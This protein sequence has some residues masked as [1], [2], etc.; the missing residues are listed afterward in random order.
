VRC[1]TAV[2]GLGSGRRVAE[3]PAAKGPDGQAVGCPSPPLSLV[4]EAAVSEGITWGICCGS[5]APIGWEASA[6]ATATP[7]P[8]A[9][10]NLTAVRAATSLSQKNFP[11]FSGNELSGSRCNEVAG[12]LL[13]DDPDLRCPP[14]GTQLL[15]GF[16]A[17]VDT[18]PAGSV[19]D[20]D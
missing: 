8:C 18:D 9:R 15:R 5:R 16:P 13:E 3:Y 11:R 19:V 17:L 1:V 2:R 20:E 4:M 12:D 14:W 7:S 6:W 10:S